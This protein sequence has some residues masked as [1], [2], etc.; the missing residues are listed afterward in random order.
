[1]DIIA[2]II[3][4]LGMICFISSFQFKNGLT[5]ILFQLIGSAFYCI[6][7]TLFSII[8]GT[9]YMG[10]LMNI[11]AVFRG[12][13]YYKGKIFRADSI[14]WIIG[15]FTSY[16]ACYIL[17]FTVFG[18]TPNA[19]NLIIEFMPILGMIIAQ[20]SF[21]L[22][23]AN[24]IRILGGATTIPWGIYHGFHL[25]IGGIIGEVVNLLS[26]IIGVIRHDVKRRKNA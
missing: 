17:L 16:I 13:V 21:R 23:S 19:H 2:Q 22:K 5:I 25:S 10:V 3:G 8:A 15:F 1:M 11:I 24:I 14:W 4:V 9:L 6:Q 7:Y 12:I 20:I 26:V 18:L